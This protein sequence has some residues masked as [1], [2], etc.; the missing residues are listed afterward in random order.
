MPDPVPVRVPEG[1]KVPEPV[2]EGL[3]PLESDGVPVPVIVAAE[4]AELDPVPVRVPVTV[5]DGVWLN[6]FVFEGDCVIEAV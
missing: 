4:V 6:V 5:L 2:N 3:A 1:V